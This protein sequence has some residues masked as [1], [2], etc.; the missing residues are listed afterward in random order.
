[1]ATDRKTLPYPIESF[2]QEMLATTGVVPKIPAAPPSPRRMRYLSWIAGAVALLGVPLG[3]P[4]RF[5]FSSSKLACAHDGSQTCQPLPKEPQR[6]LVQ[7]TALAAPVP[8]AAPLLAA[9]RP[10]HHTHGSHYRLAAASHPRA[11][12]SRARFHSRVHYSHHV[13]A[14]KPR[15]APHALRATYDSFYVRR[16]SEEPVIRIEILR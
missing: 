14:P 5:P 12:P 6:V 3:H 2:A 11:T 13:T 7:A 9:S 10:L 1:L 15:R 4:W 16:T 8:A